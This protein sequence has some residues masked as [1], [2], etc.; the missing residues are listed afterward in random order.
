M[1]P[2]AKLVGVLLLC[3]PAVLANFCACNKI[4]SFGDSFCGNHWTPEGEAPALWCYVNAGEGCVSYPSADGEQ[5]DGRFN[6]GP[7]TASHLSPSLRWA[8][9]GEPEP[10]KIGTTP[11]DGIRVEM[12]GRIQS[13]A[14][15]NKGSTVVFAQGDLLEVRH[16]LEYPADGGLAYTSANQ[17]VQLPVNATVH[18]VKMHPTAPLLVVGTTDGSLYFY[19]AATRG[20]VEGVRTGL[21]PPGATDNAVHLPE[22]FREENETETVFYGY[23]G[24]PI[25]REYGVSAVAVGDRHVFAAFGWSV[26]VVAI[27]LAEQVDGAPAFFKILGEPDF[28][29]EMFF[30]DRLPNVPALVTGVAIVGDLVVVATSDGGLRYYGQDAVGYWEQRYDKVNKLSQ[31]APPLTTKPPVDILH[32]Q[33]VYGSAGFTEEM[34]TPGQPDL[35]HPARGMRRFLEG[36][37]DVSWWLSHLRADRFAAGYE[38][39]TAVLVSKA[40]TSRERLALAAISDAI[41]DASRYDTTTR[42]IVRDLINTEALNNPLTATPDH[43]T[44]YFWS[45]ASTGHLVKTLEFDLFPLAEPHADE[46][47]ARAAAAAAVAD[48]HKVPELPHDQRPPE[49]PPAPGGG[50]NTSAPQAPV[51]FEEGELCWYADQTGGGGR[52]STL[53]GAHFGWF[54]GESACAAG[55]ECLAVAKS[56]SLYACQRRDVVDA[57]AEETARVAVSQPGDSFAYSHGAVGQVKTLRSCAGCIVKP[58]KQVYCI[59]YDHSGR[60]GSFDCVDGTAC[61]ENPADPNSCTCANRG[62]IARCP[63]DRAKLCRDGTCAAS[64]EA[65]GGEKSCFSPDEALRVV[66]APAAA[67]SS[68]LPGAGPCGMAV[69]RSPLATVQLCLEHARELVRPFGPNATATMTPPPVG[70]AP[71]CYMDAGTLP[72]GTYW[73]PPGHRLGSTELIVTFTTSGLTWESRVALDAAVVVPVYFVSDE[74]P[75]EKYVYSGAYTGVV[76]EDVEDAKEWFVRVRSNVTL[77]AVKLAGRGETIRIIEDW[78]GESHATCFAACVS[79]PACDV[80]FVHTNEEWCAL[81]SKDDPYYLN[82]EFWSVSEASDEYHL[83]ESGRDVRGDRKAAVEEA[84]PP[85]N[86]STPTTPTGTGGNVV[87]GSGAAPLFSVCRRTP[88]VKLGVG[89][90]RCEEHGL[91]TINSFHDCMRAIDT[92]AGNGLLAP[93]FQ[94]ANQDVMPRVLEWGN[95]YNKGCNLLDD[96][97]GQ[98]YYPAFKPFFETDFHYHMSSTTVAVCS[99]VPQVRNPVTPVPGPPATPAP[100]SKPN[101]ASPKLFYLPLWVYVVLV[102]GTALSLMAVAVFFHPSRFR[103][104]QQQ[105]PEPELAAEHVEG[106][107]ARY[108]KLLRGM[109]CTTDPERTLLSCTV[110][111]ENCIDGCIELPCGHVLHLKCMKDYAI[112]QIVKRRK[113]TI[114]CP[115]C[116]AV[117]VLP[118]GSEGAPREQKKKSHGTAAERNR[119]RNIE[120]EMTRGTAVCVEVEQEALSPR[121]SSYQ[122]MDNALAVAASPST[123]S[124][125][126]SAKAFCERFADVKSLT[127]TRSKSSADDLVLDQDSNLHPLLPKAPTSSSSCLQAQAERQMSEPDDEIRLLDSITVS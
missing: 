35:G 78:G 90:A 21:A 76:P 56:F 48:E 31:S 91:V 12:P 73:T 111:L 32:P 94:S 54:A 115:N 7:Y 62:G 42:G 100:T 125:T 97:E 4:A 102:L 107:K 8:L 38:Q 27:G 19:V 1:R 60:N 2:F 23:Y 123:F 101:F 105:R 47:L 58:A 64:C 118:E 55:L 99:T 20:P 85:A 81:S 83:T 17:S 18:T 126:S 24:E 46:M 3:A 109:K 74:S 88:W 14:Y 84:S 71:G 116:R 44:V 16:L 11:H 114:A 40:S 67:P 69:G 34:L 10:D 39:S 121:V 106:H 112:H 49:Q 26:A 57:E 52:K 117:L 77:D 59:W 28:L 87:P 37:H 53:L 119:E 122:S 103:R 9:C 36:A 92:L 93:E 43:Q 95:D 80:V 45:K 51:L 120:S 61:D 68:P 113:K 75:K 15:G 13:V 72:D 33:V 89:G 29:E 82:Q 66:L 5:K 65:R 25:R 110:C 41:R 6:Y 96:A 30:D 22:F 63:L 104:Q 108:K 50:A 124:R 127:R 98:G 79:D 86:Q 70:L